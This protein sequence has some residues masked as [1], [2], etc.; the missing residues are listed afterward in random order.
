MQHIRKNHLEWCSCNRW[1]LSCMWEVHWSTAC[2]YIKIEEFNYFKN[3]L[4]FKPW[5]EWLY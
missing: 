3:F 5:P 2:T 1:Q 4:Y